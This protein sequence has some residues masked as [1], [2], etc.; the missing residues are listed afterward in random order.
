MTSKQ[1]FLNY[2]NA[3]EDVFEEQRTLSSVLKYFSVYE[4][5][6]AFSNM[7]D[8]YVKML[9]ELVEQPLDTENGND[10]E[11]FI[12]EEDFGKDFQIGDMLDI[13]GTPV[14]ISTPEKLYDYILA[15]VT[16]DN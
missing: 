9:S 4:N 13:D 14:D 7:I 3:L 15:E 16:N 11:Y 1:N 6:P 2:I 12:W 8:Q 10:L 5:F